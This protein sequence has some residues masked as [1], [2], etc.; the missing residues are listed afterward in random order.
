MRRTLASILGLFAVASLLAAWLVAVPLV[1]AG[2]PCFHGFD[3][4][5]ASTS[6]SNEVSLEPCAFTPTVTNVAVGSLVT[7]KNG[8][9]FSHLV[10]GADQAW[11]SREVELQPDRSVAYRFDKAGV[12]PYAC[13]L[14]PGMSGVIVVGGAAT[15]AAAPVSTDTATPAPAP[16]TSVDSLAL[17]LVA[18]VAAIVGGVAGAAAVFLALRPRR[19]DPASLAGAN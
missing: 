3:I 1:S 18:V 11:G 9:E 10:T 15:T 7:F 13:A 19:Q 4:P 16:T 6:T 17:A 12:F 5:D 8:P 14:H 2:N